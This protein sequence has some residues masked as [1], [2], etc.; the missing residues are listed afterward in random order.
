V[1]AFHCRWDRRLLQH[2]RPGCKLPPVDISLRW[3]SSHKVRNHGR[4]AV[5]CAIGL[6]AN[7]AA[8]FHQNPI[9]TLTQELLPLYSNVAPS[10]VAYIYSWHVSTR[11]RARN[12]FLLVRQGPFLF[13]FNFPFHHLSFSVSHFP[14]SSFSIRFFFPHS[15]SVSSFLA[16]LSLKCRPLRSSYGVYS[17]VNS[18]YGLGRSLSRNGIWCILALKDTI[19]RCWYKKKNLSWNTTSQKTC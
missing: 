3:G 2:Y 7:C 15:S 8:K 6:H 9:L 14:F 1:T 19:W 11:L 12:D 17:A 5:I 16:Y 4:H 10:S 13:S 18:P